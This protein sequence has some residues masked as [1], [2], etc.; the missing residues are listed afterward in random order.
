[1]SN[2]IRKARSGK[3]ERTPGRTIVETFEQQV[4]EVLNKATNSAGKSVKNQLKYS[5]NVNAMVSAGSKG[6]SINICQIIA[7][8]AA[9]S[10]VQLADGFT[11]P[12]ERLDGNAAV[13]GFE[14]GGC[15]P[16]QQSAFWDRGLKD[17]VELQF[18]DGRTLVVTPDHR[19]MTARGWQQ[20]RDLRLMADI[21]GDGETG[22]VDEA[23]EVMTGLVAPPLP[24]RADLPAYAL[25][26]ELNFHSDAKYEKLLAFA[27]VLGYVTT[28][29]HIQD[30]RDTAL[31]IV[32]RQVDCVEL[33]RDIALL[34][35]GQRPMVTERD[36]TV[37]LTMHAALSRLLKQH[38]GQ[39]GNK[40]M[41]DFLL[42]PFIL[43]DDCPLVVVAHFLCGLFGGGGHAPCLH[44]FP[45]ADGV[46]HSTMDGLK[47]S[48]SIDRS[49]SAS[50]VAGLQQLQRLLLRFGIDS[51]LSPLFKTRR[52]NFDGDRF[53]SDE[54]G[55]TCVLSVTDPV[56]FARHIRFSYAVTKQMRLS[57]AVAWEGYQ[58]LI[59]QQRT[60]V[61]Q[62]FA[63]HKVGLTMK[64]KNQ[65]A[66]K[67]A[68]DDL[69]ATNAAIV[70]PFVTDI[71]RETLRITTTASTCQSLKKAAVWADEFVA[72]VG[73]AEWFRKADL[74]GVQMTDAVFPCMG[75][76]VVRRAP[77]G[78]RQV[79][80]I[81]VDSAHS[82]IASQAVVHNCVGQ[83]NVNGKRIPFGFKQ[84]SLPHFNK[85]S[86][87]QPRTRSCPPRCTHQ[88]DAH[89]H[90][91]HCVL[92][93]VLPRAL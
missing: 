75:M 64:N 14:G 39:A 28:D 3:L 72:M 42:P 49:L 50:L 70:H 26:A 91:L 20:A 25:S 89:S 21:V 57:V 76:K 88:T 66:L 29:G 67:R 9:G 30:T 36:A 47:F 40:H 17:C 62:S 56:L 52:G 85:V 63:Q 11:R 31:V 35:G 79:Y 16:R 4:N 53:Q 8:V 82:F 68:I 2:I 1:M 55:V 48:R 18:I 45:S 24:F 13:T 92:C 37:K 38:G 60:Q 6:S 71:S 44:V 81:Q 22:E 78:P 73:A 43:D 90:A 93:S 33:T 51:S 23:D 58:R 84:R 7:C 87:R 54:N 77:V 61:L 41:Q 80:D 34:Q 15:L 65:A 10:P 12:I 83:Q 5:N 74:Y 86:S 46:P 19:V 59:K 69:R 32:K 27:R